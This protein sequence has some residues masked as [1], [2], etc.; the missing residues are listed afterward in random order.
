MKIEKNQGKKREKCEKNMGKNKNCCFSHLP[1]R[2]AA[3]KPAASAPAA[4]Q[5]HFHKVFSLERVLILLSAES[6]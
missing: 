6:R 3:P 1:A 2:N 4:K 5:P